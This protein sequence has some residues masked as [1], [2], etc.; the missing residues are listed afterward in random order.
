[1]GIFICGDIV[2]KPR[3][4]V[5]H[6]LSDIIKKNLSFCN[7]E[8]PI[9]GVGVPIIKA[10]PHM[11]QDSH[12]ITN[13]ANLGF[14]VFCLANNHIFDYGADALQSTMD[15]ITQHKVEYIGSYNTST[16]PPIITTQINNTRIGVINGGESQFGALDGVGIFLDA[17]CGYVDLFDE[18]FVRQITELRASVDVLIAI[19]H[20]GLES[21]DLPLPQFRRFYKFLCDMGVD[22][23]VGHHPHWAQGY[24]SYY[25]RQRE[26]LIFYSLGNFAFCMPY[27][28]PTQREQESFSVLLDFADG[29]LKDFTLF[30]HKQIFT[31]NACRVE[32]CQE[33]DVSFSIQELNEILLDE[34]RYKQEILALAKKHYETYKFYYDLAFLMPTKQLSLWNNVKVLCKRWFFPTKGLYQREA[35]LL[36]NIHIP[37]HRF[38]QEIALRAD[39]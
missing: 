18:A 12:I 29:K 16:P 38:V 36:H 33:T 1:M 5:C 11:S 34:Q 28:V 39:I 26:C 25:T 21:V 30:F 31:P 37:T 8:A 2:S 24:E 19:V 17:Q 13:L 27:N 7:L 10:G 32:L 6:E 22:I 20:A 15:M 3:I 14:D 23:I 35:L 9:S 4:E